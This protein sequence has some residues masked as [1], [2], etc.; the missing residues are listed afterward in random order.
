M[1]RERRGRG[2]AP[3]GHQQGARVVLLGCLQFS[4]MVRIHSHCLLARSGPGQEGME[5]FCSCRSQKMWLQHLQMHPAAASTTVVRC[6]DFSSSSCAL[7]W[8]S[9]ELDLHSPRLQPAS[10]CCCSAPKPEARLP[11]Q[12][13]GVL[14]EGANHG[15]SPALH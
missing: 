12:C 10:W 9:A 3:L 13:L 7:L 6:Q 15:A 11:A 14:R 4:Q 1:C 5:S 8:L 2:L